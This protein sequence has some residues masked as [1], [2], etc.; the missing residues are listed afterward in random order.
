[1]GQAE[2]P[3]KSAMLRWRPIRL[4]GFLLILLL[5]LVPGI[6]KT[7]YAQFTSGIAGT[8]VDSSGAAIPGAT[9]TLVDVERGVTKSTVSNSSG[10]FQIDNVAA[11]AYRVQVEMTNFKTWTEE[12]LTLQAG[13][14]RTLSPVLSPGSTSTTV[15][16]S[17]TAAA[18]N[19]ST[20]T[21]AAVISQQTISQ[22]PLVGQN[23]YTLASLAPGMMG[24]AVTSGDNYSNGYDLN[25][26]A[27]GQR[28]EANSFS[29]DGAYIDITS[30]GGE[31]AISPNPEVVQYMQL[32]TNEFDAEKGRNSGANFQLYTKSGTNQLHG[33]AD[34]FFLNNTLTARSEFQSTIPTFQRNEFGATLGGPILK[35]KVFGFGAF[36]VLRSTS[37]N[38]YLTTVETQD[39]YNYAKSTFPN[40][41]ATTVLTLAPPQH[42]PTT[43]LLTVAQVEQQFPGYYPPPPGISASM[44]AIGNININYSVP[45][46]GYQYDFR[47][48]EYIGEH[49]RIYGEALRFYVNSFS[50]AARPATNGPTPYSTTL[51]NTGWTH[52]FSSRLVN[53]TGLSYLRPYG[54]SAPVA[55]DSLPYIS[56]AGINGVGSWGPGNFVL[57]TIGWRDVMTATI[58]S[59]QLRFGVDIENERENDAQSGANNRPS[60]TFNNLLDFVQDLAVSES[61]TPVNLKTLGP[62]GLQR[63]DRDLYTGAFIQDDWKASRNLNLNLGLRY[64]TFYRYLAYIGPPLSIF[65]LGTGTT[66]PQQI[67]NGSIGAPPASQGNNILTHNIWAFNPRFGFAWDVFG[68]GKTALRG[69][70]GLF[71]D[72]PPYLEFI[73]NLTANLPFDYTPSISVYQGDSTPVFQGCSPPDGYNENCPVIVPPNISFDSRGGIVGQRATIGGYSPNIK[74]AQVENWSLSIEQQLKSDLVL[75]LNYSGSAG[76][77]LPVSTDVNRYAGDLIQNDGSQA[78]LNP[79]FAAINYITT[80]TNSIGNYGT[81]MITRRTSNGLTFHGIYTWGKAIDVYSTDNSLSGGASTSIIEAY[82]FGFQRGRSDYDIRQQAS[83]DGVWTIPNLW[84]TGWKHNALGGWLLSGVAIFHTGIPFTVYTSAPFQPVFNPSGQVVGNSGGDYNADG[85]NYDVPNKPAFGSHLSGRSPK[86]YLTG[87]FPASAFPAPPLGQ[88]GNL[89]RNTYDQPGYSNI[90]LSLAKLFYVPWF[91]GNKMNLEFRGEFFN[92]LNR[93]NLNGVD[94][95]LVDTTFAQATGQEPARSIQ[96]HVRA[97]F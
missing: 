66:Y 94:G 21:T 96:L 12:K 17:A 65:T 27:A 63:N 64:D 50:A 20:A 97:S 25:V 7:A 10:Y 68:N 36:D 34:Y 76:H 75:Q 85:Y 31:A 56:V 74:M 24:V 90:D 67:A 60:Y 40:N 6:S 53:Q 8:V 23:V 83:I 15:A 84:A 78:R 47:G 14:V 89:G 88:E 49:D 1:M 48:D 92:L 52:T 37:T 44:P 69:G 81:A 58:K 9:V 45:R 4:K 26:N 16:V 77:Y 42:Y 61:A 41:Y 43:G 29:L 91:S 13:E 51:I 5:S 57:N 79:S 86:K 2:R 59:H 11:S 80:N 22:T 93:V 46:N 39:F 35:G 71:S 38:A 3:L 19:L 72:K 18:L 30:R 95:N 32:N 82:N 70:V 55:S 73:S 87:L 33:T 62:A 28:Q 54:A